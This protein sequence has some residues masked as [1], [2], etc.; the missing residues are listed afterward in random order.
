VKSNAEIIKEFTD[1]KAQTLQRQ[2]DNTV[3]CLEFY[4]GDF[5]A[6]KDRVET[7][8]GRGRKQSVMI[9]FNKVKPYVNAVK[10]FMAQNR[11]KAKYIARLTDDA[12]RVQYSE[13]ANAYHDYIRENANADQHETQVDGDMLTCG[14]GAIETAMSYGDGYVTTDPNGEIIK[15]RLDP[16]CVG[17]DPSARHAN[18]LDARWVWYKKEY[19]RQEAIDLLDAD[20]DDFEDGR[21]EQGPKRYNPDGGPY[22]AVIDDLEYASKPKDT[23]NVYFYQ[24][25]EIENYYRANNPLFELTDPAETQF[26]FMKLQDVAGMSEE[27]SM[28]TLD[29]RARILNC[30]AG[31]M[32]ALREFFGESVVFTKFKRRAYFGAVLSGSKVFSSFRLLTQQGFTIKFKTGDWND[33]EKRWEGLVNPMMDPATYYSKAMTEL[34]YTIAAGAKGGVMF[35]KSAIKKIREFEARYNDP[36]AAVEVEDGALSGGKIQA[37]REIYQPT[38]LEQLL[39]LSDQAIPDVIGIDRTFLGSSESRLET[40]ALQ[41]QRI[42]QVTSVLACYFDAVTL[43]QRE[44]GRLMLD[45]M[46]ILAENNP[47]ALFRVTGADGQ[48]MLVPLDPDKLSAEYDVAI[49]EAPTTPTEKEE[50]AAILTGMA[51]KL[52]VT[53]DP[54]GKILLA[55]AIKDMGLSSE[56]KAKVVQALTPEEPQI[57]PAYVKQLEAALQEAMGEVQQADVKEKLSKVALNIANVGKIKAETQKSGADT[58][59]TLEEAEQAGLENQNMRKI[60]MKEKKPAIRPVQTAQT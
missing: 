56:D 2:Y 50:R 42:K 53:G 22:T 45:M 29:P 40:A 5:M 9:Q 59:K 11:R 12:E 24:W 10:G 20:E 3:K 27:D 52:L 43:Y 48:V 58:V 23:V 21:P 60:G 55:M 28:F 30:S 6:W 25:Y 49:E 34:L 15:G 31:Q 17:W 26:A 35:E 57:D 32:Q 54:A 14:Y 18:L 44:D 36:S 46:R 13:H 38:G 19:D 39:Q 51:D 1:R 4:S 16:L 7:N 33:K 41:R 47:T 37:K 8:A